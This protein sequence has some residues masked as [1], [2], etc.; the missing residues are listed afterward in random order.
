[1]LATEMMVDGAALPR[2]AT[3]S[4]PGLSSL[5]QELHD[6]ADTCTSGSDLKAEACAASANP[7]PQPGWS[8]GAGALPLHLQGLFRMPQPLGLQ[9]QQ[10][11]Q[12]AGLGHPG[13]QHFAHGLAPAPFH[14]AFFPASQPHAQHAVSN[15][16]LITTAA[17]PTA[18][19]QPQ[20]QPQHQPQPAFTTGAG[21]PA[22]AV[23]GYDGA[24]GAEPLGGRR[25]RK[26][27]PRLPDLQ[28]QVEGL[29]DQFKRLSHENGFLRNKLKALERVVPLRD[30][31]LGFLEEVKTGGRGARSSSSN[32]GAGAGADAGG[33]NDLST[34]VYAAAQQAARSVADT[35]WAQASG[36]LAAAATVTGWPGRPEATAA[37]AWGSSSSSM[38][39]QSSTTSTSSQGAAP[40]RE[41]AA[42]AGAWGGAFGAAVGAPLLLA[43]CPGPDGEVPAIPPSACEALKQITPR[44]FQQLWKHFTLQFGVLMASADALGPE[45]PQSARLGRFFERILTYLDKV[46]LLAP[47]AFIASMHV[48]IET[49]QPDAPDDTFWYAIGASLNLNEQQLEEVDSI[50]ELYAHNVAPVLRERV[51]LAHELSQRL[52]A[53]SATQPGS[54]AENLTVLS[55]VDELAERLRQNVLKEHQKHWDSGDF[56]CL[57]CL[58]PYQVAKALAASY[59]YIPDGAFTVGSSAGA[60]LPGCS[61]VRVTGNRRGRKPKPRQADLER[62]LDSLAEQFQQLSQENGFLR[63]KLKVLERVV[64]YRDESVG[65]IAQ[66]LSQA[67]ADSQ[68]QEEQAVAEAEAG[69]PSSTQRQPSPAHSADVGGGASCS[70]AAGAAAAASGSEQTSC[71]RTSSS[72]GASASASGAFLQSARRGG[73]AAGRPSASPPPSRSGEPIIVQL[74]PTPDGT[75]PSITAATVEEM[76]RV[77][78]DHFRLL[79]KHI[80]LQLGVLVAGAEVH[81][82]GSSPY[83][84]MERFLERILA[85]LDKITLLSPASFLQTMYMNVETGQQERPPDQ[86][87]LT[88]ARSLQ[89]TLQQ[90]VEVATLAQVYQQNV[91]PVMQQRLQLSAELSTRLASA[92]SPTGSSGDAFQAVPEVDDLAKQLQRNV[93]KEHQ[94]HWEIGDFLCSSV[95]TPLQVSKALAVC[96]PYI[97]DGV[98]MLHAFKLIS[99]NIGQ[100][101]S[102]AG[103]QFPSLPGLLASHLPAIGAL[104]AATRQMQ[105]Q[106]QQQGASAAGRPAPN[107]AGSAAGGLQPQQLQ[108]LMAM[109]SGAAQPQA[110]AAAAAVPPTAAQ[111][112]GVAGVL[113]SGQLQG[114]AGALQA[115]PLQA[116][117]GA[118]QPGQLQAILAGLQAVGGRSS[119]AAPQAPSFTALMADAGG[120]GAPAPA[121][122]AQRSAS[123]GT[124]PQGNAPRSG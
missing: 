21:F 117:A 24:A 124:A 26:G 87:W 78:P 35:S 103:Q 76:K 69:A 32:G 54:S 33:G 38:A 49:G 30:V 22:F 42:S 119:A 92:A 29:L 113:Q 96:F 44:Q 63:N 36:S 2:A 68:V 28:Q 5:F 19:P 116:L 101:P 91:I 94:A 100:G 56:L 110:A 18:Q 115:G 66:L 48:N 72:G 37:G 85:Y 93:L 27:R 8:T 11:A 81:G 88:C 58:S 112:L 50:A 6:D 121:Q 97:P 55:E 67:E 62:Q 106:Q 104:M 12:A 47:L 61:G 10:Q 114:L 25:G 75:A 51:Q 57:S 15:T 95:L 111:L 23:P 79:W 82:P 89:L 90:L 102:Q 59:P 71:N 86:F 43:L 13:P 31:S 1:M 64:P 53:V 4:S 105:Q 70:A 46:L 98:A 40:E 109:L 60:P 107:A 83:V 74:C 14:H 20:H 16:N 122:A 52:T 99:S 34:A 108:A 84:R 41:A 118:L 77:T 39:G 45:S 17:V 7:F 120:L 80:C 73:R 123:D 65:F 3:P 9:L